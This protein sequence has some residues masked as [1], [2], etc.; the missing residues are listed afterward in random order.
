MAL[1][2]K[3][4]IGSSSND[5]TNPLANCHDLN[6]RLLT[7]VIQIATLA[8]HMNYVAIGMLLASSLHYVYIVVT[9]VI[10][11]HSYMYCTCLQWP[12][13]IRTTDYN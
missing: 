6:D 7:V 5:D 13:V 4:K 9:I 12:W 10:Y 8:C 1:G 2:L 3:S 11:K